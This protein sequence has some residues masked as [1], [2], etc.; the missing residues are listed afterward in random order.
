MIVMCDS[1]NLNWCGRISLLMSIFSILCLM[2]FQIWS[3]YFTLVT[4]MDEMVLESPQVQ[5]VLDVCGG[6]V[7]RAWNVD[8]CAVSEDGLVCEL[9][10]AFDNLY[11]DYMPVSSP[12]VLNATHIRV[13]SEFC[14]RV[15]LWILPW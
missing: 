9:T 5:G 10:S 13:T 12:P 6:Q 1:K 7:R 2:M 15:M 4:Q 8:N 3:Y 11:V 14:G